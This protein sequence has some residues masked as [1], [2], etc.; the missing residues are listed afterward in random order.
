MRKQLK[1]VG[2]DLALARAGAR[3]GDTVRIGD[4]E[5]DYEADEPL[6]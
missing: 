6:P 5:F 1:K 2:V 4:L 3:P